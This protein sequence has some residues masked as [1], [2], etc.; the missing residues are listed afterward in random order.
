M[1]TAR[2][3]ALYAV[4][5]PRLQWSARLAADELRELDGGLEV[6][7]VLQ[8]LGRFVTDA[9]EGWFTD[10]EASEEAEVWLAL[11]S[12]A[13]LRAPA[14]TRFLALLV[15][16]AGASS[17]P[18][19]GEAPPANPLEA[20]ARLARSDD[21]A[22]PALWRALHQGS[23]H[24]PV[25][26]HDLILPGGKARFRLL[27]VPIGGSAVVLGFTTEQHLD[28][29]APEA[30]RIEAK[31]EELA[32]VWP[33]EHWLVLDAG[34]PHAVLLA[35][36]EVTGLPDGPTQLLPPPEAVVITP[37]HR[38]DGRWPPVVAALRDAGATRAAWATIRA[39]SGPGEPREVVAVVADDPASAGA[40]LLRAL[41][42]PAHLGWAFLPVDPVAPH[43]L[44]EAVLSQGLPWP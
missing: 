27:A 38:A 9:G 7:E 4:Q 3:S 1:D 24:I 31:G 18:P 2:P 37:G 13:G 19:A 42:G 6:A 16:G 44:A 23:V 12:A 14:L 5:R 40:A 17:P 10:A 15:K 22:R 34:T 25:L 11:L 35:P 30:G 8:D 43:P 26:H 36:S 20:A 41:A 28:A 29:L 39:P 32:G 33:E 21:Q